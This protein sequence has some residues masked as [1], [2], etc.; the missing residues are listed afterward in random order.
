MPAAPTHPLDLIKVRKQLQGESLKAHTAAVHGF[1]PAL[2]LHTA[3]VLPP[4]PKVGPLAVGVRIVQSEGV[5]ALFSGVSATVLRQT[6]Y[7]TTCMGLYN[8]LKQKW[9]DS[10]S[11]HI[12]LTSKITAGLIAVAVGAS[13]GN[14]ANVAM[15]RMQADGR[16][17][18]SQRRNYKSVIDAITSMSKQEG[19]FRFE[20][21]N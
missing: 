13:V 20:R 12:P 15:V 6:L 19:Q 18:P 7:S 5:K 9:T 11:K 3:S 4:P 8:I 17:A 21:N 2:D 10:E 16:L 14:P 1:R